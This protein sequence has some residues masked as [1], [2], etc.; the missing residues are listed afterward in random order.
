MLPVQD[1]SI[2]EKVGDIRRATTLLPEKAAIARELKSPD[3][4][5]SSTLNYTYINRIM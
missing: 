1:F 2:F 4:L 3:F 5:L